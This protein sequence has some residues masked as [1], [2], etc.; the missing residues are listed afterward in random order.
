MPYFY[1]GNINS[2]LRFR[3]GDAILIFFAKSSLPIFSFHT[4]TNTL[5]IMSD[6]LGSSSTRR[7]LIKC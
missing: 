3:S 7:I 1:I 4:Y 6:H 5:V 2:L